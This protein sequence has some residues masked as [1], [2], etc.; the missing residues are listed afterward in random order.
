MSDIFI[1]L[2]QIVAFVTKADP[3]RIIVKI[4]SGEKLCFY[5]LISV[6]KPLIYKQ[7]HIGLKQD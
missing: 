1:F 6:T 2:I 7:P 5:H 4:E 3:V